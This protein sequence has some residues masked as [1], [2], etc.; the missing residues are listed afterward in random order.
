MLRS[1]RHAHS[2]KQRDT[3][4][5]NRNYTENTHLR[6]GHDFVA[7]ED[8][9]AACKWNLHEDNYLHPQV[10]NVKAAH[11]CMFPWK[12]EINHYTMLALARRV[13]YIYSTI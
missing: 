13:I 10:R 5:K 11:I 4:N 2:E 3:C 7:P 12:R 8:R 6:S 9:V 1:H